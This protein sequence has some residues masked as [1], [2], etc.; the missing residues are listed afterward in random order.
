MEISSGIGGTNSILALQRGNFSF[1]K[2]LKSLF[3]KALGGGKELEEGKDKDAA[4]G[5]GNRRQ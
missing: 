3:A 2:E 4:Q 1:K 5:G